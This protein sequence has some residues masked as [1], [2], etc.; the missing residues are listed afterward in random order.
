MLIKVA[1]Y[2]SAVIVWLII[3][4][5]VKRI[6]EILLHTKLLDGVE[7][8]WVYFA[9]AMLSGIAALMIAPR[10]RLPIFPYLLTAIVVFLTPFTNEDINKDLFSCNPMWGSTFGY[11]LSVCIVLIPAYY[12]KRSSKDT[13]SG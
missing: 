13:F 9:A 6:G 7:G 10:T 8:F 11:M 5:G 3:F 2:I 12:K 4:L 1:R